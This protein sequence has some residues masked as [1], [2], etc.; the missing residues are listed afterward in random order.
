[1]QNS[2]NSLWNSNFSHIYVEKSA[3]NHPNTEKILAY[4][5]NTVVVEIDHYKEV[6]CRGHQSFNMQK[7]S[8]KLI[9]ATKKDNLIYEGA[10]VCENFGNAHFYYTSSMMN[11]IY[12]CEYCYL[13]GMYPS[14]NIVIFVN[15][16]D[17]FNEVEK[18]LEKH[19]VYLCVSYDSDLLAF[20]GIT[21]FATSWMKFANK[22]PDLKIELRTKSANFKAIRDIDPLDNTILAWTLSPSKVISKYE[23]K[24][25]SSKL[26]LESIRDA[27]E[28]GWT[29]RICFDPL[30]YTKDWKKEYKKLVEETFKVL[31]A[32]KIYDISIGVFRVAKDYLKKMQKERTHSLLLSYPFE[33]KNG[34]CSYSEKQTREMIDF[35]YKEVCKFMPKK[36]IYI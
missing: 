14:A 2:K 17:I 25:P 6:F 5:K 21:S 31:P 11:C 10:D 12:N 28:K 29:V 8:T 27:V 32:E 36:K 19:P 16:E 4:F 30:L 26:R 34:V 22:H 33:C 13:Q 20:E 9:L 3:L 23:E 1:M 18:L 24:T 7:R 35:V 15:I